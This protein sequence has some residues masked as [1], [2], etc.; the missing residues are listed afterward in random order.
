MKK[1][2]AIDEKV[3][4]SLERLHKVH[5]EKSGKEI[6]LD[7]FIELML[8]DMISK[9]DNSRISS[10]IRGKKKGAAVSKRKNTLPNGEVIEFS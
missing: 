2:I 3:L 7:D 1:T 10:A 9:D 5:S 8:I 4:K 6:S